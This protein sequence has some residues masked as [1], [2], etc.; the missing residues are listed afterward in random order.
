M[1]PNENDKLEGASS[2]IAIPFLPRRRQS[3]SIMSES[4]LSRKS[5]AVMGAS[6]RSGPVMKRFTAPGQSPPVGARSVESR[7]LV[8]IG[9]PNFKT[10]EQKQQD[11]IVNSLRNY[12]L[13]DYMSSKRKSSTTSMNSVP[14]STLDNEDAI[15]DS[16]NSQD[17][18]ILHKDPHLNTV[19]GDIT[20]ELYRIGSKNGQKRKT[21]NRSYDDLTLVLEPRRGSTASALN[22]PGGFRREFIVSKIRK[23]VGILSEGR[24]AVES[25]YTY[26][27]IDKVPFLTRNFLEFLYV[28]G[29]FA[30]ESFD[31]EFDLVQTYSKVIDE[32]TPLL[33]GDTERLHPITVRVKTSTFKAFLLLI[34]SFVGTGVLFLPNAFSNGGL[35]FSIIML[36]IFS[37]YSYWC[38]YILVR[39]KVSTGVSSFGDIG[40]MLYGPWMKYIILFSLVFAQLGFSSAYVVFT[41]KNLIAFIQNVFHYPDIPMAYMLLLQLIIFIPLS[42][43]RNVSKLSL[44]SL[45][46][47]FLII[48]G[49]FIVVLYSAKHL[50]VDLSF[51]PEEGVIFLFNSK[52]W[53]LFVGTAIFAYE[54]IGLIIPVQDSMAHPEKFP[55]VLGWVIITTTA[56]FVLVGSLGYLAYGKY[57]QSVILLNL[58]QKSLSVNLIQF[59]YSMAIL[60]STPLQLFP[61]IAIIENKIFPKF[62]KINVKPQGLPSYSLIPYSGRLNWK[63]KW[64]KNLVRSIIVIFIITLAYVGADDLDLFV[65]VIG[66]FACIPLV[67]MYPP[68]LHLRS[69]SKP[70]HIANPTYRTLFAVILDYFLIFFGGVSACYT[71]YQCLAG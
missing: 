55:M 40:A 11:E 53:T 48:C 65:S 2:N 15:E 38:Y 20:R 63:I 31:E 9:S 56:L 70:Q 45:L 61:A 29:H 18:F 43:V 44:S 64:T 49:L 67:Y 35:A 14:T 28:D 10:I 54:G 60:L 33:S 25:S 68:L 23:D 66:C 19:G 1:E 36:F 39:T 21:K 30:G 27:N 26:N 34:K 50:I 24:T 41:S 3:T 37:G 8:D 7:V 13:N 46:A 5:S 16:G 22:V 12:Y 17:D 58:P 57:I 42:F 32:T 47:N 52:K 51:K 69:C 59:F 4:V 6:Y 71:T 62:T